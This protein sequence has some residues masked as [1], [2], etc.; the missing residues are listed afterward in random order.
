MESLMSDPRGELLGRVVLRKVSLRLLPF[1]FLLYVVNILDRV[2]VSFAKFGM[3]PDLGLGGDEGEKVFALGFGIFYI[4]YLLFEVPSNLVLHRVG[5]RAWIGRI[6]VSWGAV[7]AAMMFV[8]GP[9]SFYALRFLLGVA[10]AGFFPGIIL[11]LSY[12]FPARERARA[13]A[14]FMMASPLAGVLGNPVSG[15]V[16]QYL[17]RAGGLAGWQWLFLLEGV[18]A[19]LLGVG[20]W[21]YLTDRPEQ[22]RWLTPAERNWLVARLGAEAR[23]RAAQ[24]GLTRLSAMA[25]PRVWLLIALYFTVAV[26]SNAFGAYSPTI[27]KGHFPDAKPLGLG[28]LTAVPSVA[29]V[30]GMVVIGAHSDAT[31]ERRLHVAG[32]ALLAAAGWTLTATATDRWVALEGLVL[33]QV[34]MMSMLPTFWA[35]A[36]SFLSGTAAAGGIALINS[37][38]N[39]GGFLG[40]NVLGR[41]KAA[42]GDYTGAMVVLAQVLFAG[43]LLALCVRHDSVPEGRTEAPAPAGDG[44]AK[45]PA[46]PID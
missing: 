24:H 15:A 46:P 41:L 4:G 43:A 12:W 34:G 42:T 7:S 44:A 2:N 36:T 35:L 19:V 11:Y 23:D 27:I 26:G 22:A 32:S 30:V 10:E 16:L 25:H 31:G 5:A 6:M 28:L 21:F 14:L 29:A 18:P 33:A 40:P 8:R 17:D 39:L 9:W 13:V 3:L 38:A 45:S 20:V 37:V 1:L